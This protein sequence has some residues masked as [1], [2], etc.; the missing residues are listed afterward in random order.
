VDGPEILVRFPAWATHCSLL[1]SVHSDPGAHP[2]SYSMSTAA[3]S[4]EV[5]RPG[6]EADHLPQSSADCLSIHICCCDKLQL[7]AQGFRSLIRNLSTCFKLEERGGGVQ[8]QAT[9]SASDDTA[10]QL[11]HFARL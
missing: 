5:K 11:I 10:E 9:R 3:L 4:L 7:V 1:Q 2:T 8:Y 6:L